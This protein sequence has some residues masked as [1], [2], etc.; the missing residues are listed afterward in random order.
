MMT[1]NMYIII[2]TLTNLISSMKVLPKHT[3]YFED[4]VLILELG[5]SLFALL[6]NINSLTTICKAL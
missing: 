5:E 6:L 4:I 3:I 1:L 2:V